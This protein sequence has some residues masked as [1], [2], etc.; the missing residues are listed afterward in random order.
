VLTYTIGGTVSG[1]AGTGLTLQNNSSN[2]LAVTANGSFIFTTPVANGAAYGVTV[3]NQPINPSQTCSVTNGS[4]SVGAANIANVAVRCG[5]EPEGVYGGTLTGSTSSAFE[6]LVLDTGE[7]WSLYGTQTSTNFVVAGFVQ[8]TGNAS[9]GSFASSN[10]KDFGFRPAVA[11][12][13]NASYNKTAK[14]ISGTVSSTV[15]TVSFSGGPIAGSL[16]NYDASASLST[17]SGSWSTTSTTGETIALSVNSSGA[18]AATSSLGCSF[19]GTVTPRPSGKNVFNVTLSFGP[20]PCALS[21][22][23]ATGIAVAY[24]LPSGGLTQLIV[25]VTDSARTLG[26]AAFGTR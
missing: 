21:G 8:G 15:G 23:T 7:F 14:T 24:P 6:M 19:T 12:T 16:Y 26:V 10:A 4:G 9:N 3:F 5:T 22:Q 17:V 13:V 2:N 18:L 11:D 20:A 1:L 25:G